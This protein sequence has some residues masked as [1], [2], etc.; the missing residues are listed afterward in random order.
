M[1]K[2]FFSKRATFILIGLCVICLTVFKKNV[3]KLILSAKLPQLTK[4]YSNQNPE[5]FYQANLNDLIEIEQKLSSI[6]FFTIGSGGIHDASHILNGLVSW[7]NL[8]Q[9]LKL[10][11]T[12]NNQLSQ[13]NDISTIKINWNNYDLDFQ[14]MQV[15]KKFDHWSFDLASPYKQN[16][17]YTPYST[18]RP[19]FQE[20]VTWGQ[21]R[22]LKG[23]DNHDLQQALNEVRQLARLL[24]STESKAGVNASIDLLRSETQVVKKTLLDDNSFKDWPFI[25]I[26]L[27]DKSKLLFQSRT[28]LL[29]PRISES[30]F[31]RFSQFTVGRCFHIFQSLHTHMILRQYFSEKYSPSIDRMKTLESATQLGCRKSL[32]RKAWNSNTPWHIKPKQLFIGSLNSQFF[33]HYFIQSLSHSDYTKQ[34][35]LGQSLSLILLTNTSN[36]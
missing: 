11:T 9:A 1:K 15:L 2:M 8:P 27:L 3:A 10:P 17:N 23:R 34:K 32:V 21:L 16:S 12:L 20:L 4:E 24:Y 35:E 33:I 13:T 19:D 6:A 18:S 25:S 31:H 36:Q 14:W 22:L 7:P 28:L 29:D 30:L 26:E 5:A